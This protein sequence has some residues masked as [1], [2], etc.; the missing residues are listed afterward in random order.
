MQSRFC[1]TKAIL[2]IASMIAIIA[3]LLVSVRSIHKPPALALLIAKELPSLKLT[4]WEPKSIKTWLLEIYGDEE[5][6]FLEVLHLS[7]K[8]W[9]YDSGECSCRVLIMDVPVNALGYGFLPE[10][11]VRFVFSPKRDRIE[12]LD[13]VITREMI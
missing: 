11:T 10:Q 4:A 5:K 3:L 6:I 7:G 1:A 8:S 9:F 12:L 2:T 13:A